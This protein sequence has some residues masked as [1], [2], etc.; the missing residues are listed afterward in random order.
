VIGT[1]AADLP[2]IGW[3]GIMLTFQRSAVPRGKSGGG[4]RWSA[5][6]VV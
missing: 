3:L 2:Y 1:I 4:K 6:P 5:V